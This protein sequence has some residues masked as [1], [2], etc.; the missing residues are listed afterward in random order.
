MGDKSFFLLFRRLSCLYILLSQSFYSI[1]VAGDL[2]G[3]VRFMGIGYK[4]PGR[5]IDFN[6]FDD[7]ENLIYQWLCHLLF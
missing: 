2:S 4:S 7:G 3:R 5:Q 1:S 6:F